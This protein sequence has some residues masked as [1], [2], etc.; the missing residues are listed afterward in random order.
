M[1]DDEA[2]LPPQDWPKT[3]VRDVIYCAGPP[4]YCDYGQTVD[5]CRQWLAQEHPEMFARLWPELDLQ[6]TMEGVTLTDAEGTEQKK[7]KETKAEKEKKKKAS[8]RVTIKRVERTKRKCVIAVTGMENFDVDLK[9]AAKLFAT[10]FA[11]GASVTKNPQ[12]LDEI[13]VQGDVQDDIY[14][15]ILE[16]WE[17]V[18]EEQ[19]DLTEGKLK[20]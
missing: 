8:A 9:K 3:E 4:E 5:A 12:G 16:T 10:K 19:I 11:C 7:P 6:K 18:P 2:P 17:Q 13:I 15:L 20:K 1:S 14:D